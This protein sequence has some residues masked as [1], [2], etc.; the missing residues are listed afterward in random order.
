MFCLLGAIA[1]GP[2][3]FPFGDGLAMALALVVEAAIFG[4]IIGALLGAVFF[5]LMFRH[6]TRGESASRE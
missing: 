2:V 5:V 3:F 1:G 4:G 6:P